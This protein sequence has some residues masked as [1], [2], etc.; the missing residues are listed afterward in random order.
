[1]SAAV[2]ETAW[3]AVCT[4][5][6]LWVDRGA[7]ALVDGDQVAIFRLQDG[8]ILAVGH[9]D[10]FTGSNVIARGLVGSRGDVPTV[11]SPL[12]KQVFDLRTG[13]CLDEPEVTLG[14]WD[15]RVVDDVVWLRREG[16]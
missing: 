6:R 7:A 5:D 12:H 16:A 8:E 15:V 2:S 10:P 14:R 13:V 1:M 3:T 11:A 9:R 4:V